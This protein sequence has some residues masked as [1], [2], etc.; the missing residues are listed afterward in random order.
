MSV[1]SGINQVTL[2]P[3]GAFRPLK[4]L[5]LTLTS[6]YLLCHMLL[7]PA[8]TIQWCYN[9]ALAESEMYAKVKDAKMHLKIDLKLL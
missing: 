8:T 3:T 5:T 6:I 7:R 1:N 9:S 4:L 2:H